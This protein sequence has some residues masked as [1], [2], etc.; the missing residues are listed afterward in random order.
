[1]EKKTSYYG[2]AIRLQIGYVKVKNDLKNPRV[3]AETEKRMSRNKMFNK[4]HMKKKISILM[5]S[6]MF[7]I[8]FSS[9]HPSFATD[10][11]PEFTKEFCAVSQAEKCK[12]T[13]TGC[14]AKKVCFWKDLGDIAS[15]AGKIVGTA[16]AAVALA[17]AID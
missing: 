3:T 1:M 2:L 5:S 13:G 17:E 4:V 14:P 12:Q 11:K 10:T 9:I 7:V 16:A 15:T 6:L 8:S